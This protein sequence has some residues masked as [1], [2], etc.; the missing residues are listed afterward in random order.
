MK[1]VYLVVTIF[2]TNIIIAQTKIPPTFEYFNVGQSFTSIAVEKDPLGQVWAGTVKKGLFNKSTS[3]TSFNLFTVPNLELYTIKTIATDYSGN[4]WV[5]HNGLLGG[6]ATGGGIELISKLE[7][8][9]HLY[10]RRDNCFYKGVQVQE[11]DGYASRNVKSITVNHNNTVWVAQGNYDVA[12]SS[13][14]IVTPGTLSFKKA[15]SSVFLSKS[16]YSDINNPNP[17]LP[18]PAYTCSPPIGKTAG[19]RVCNSI[20]TDSTKVWMAVSPYETV[21]NE[22]LPARIL[23]YNLDGVF[24]KSY[25]FS[26]IG[27]TPGAV[28][29]GVYTNNKLGAWVTSNFAG[30]GFS[31]LKNGQWYHMDS[32]NFPNI[33]PASAIFNN[34]AIWGN[35]YGNV[36]MGTDKGLIVYDGRGAVNDEKSYTLYNQARHGLISENILG[37]ASELIVDDSPEELNYK[38]T[39]WIA[40]DNGIIK[41]NIGAV[42]TDLNP[43]LPEPSKNSDVK[44]VEEEFKTRAGKNDP[45]YH[46]YFL[47]TEICDTKKKYGIPCTQEQVYKYVAKNVKYQAV[48]PYVFNRDIIFPGLLASL[49]NSDLNQIY[50]I[51]N[52]QK[53]SIEYVSKIFNIAAL[54]GNLKFGADA[55]RRYSPRLFIINSA[56]EIANNL[57]VKSTDELYKTQIRANLKNCVTNTRYKLYN[58][59]N[60]INMRRVF[61]EVVNTEHYAPIILPF[62]PIF[63]P[64]KVKVPKAC[65]PSDFLESDEYDPITLWIDDKNFSMTNYTNKG[66]FLHPGYVKRKIIIKDDGKIYVTTEGKGYHFCN[67]PDGDV[68]SG[69]MSE[70]AKGINVIV[71]SIMFKNIDIN[72]KNAFTNEK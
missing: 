69:L 2:V 33:I 5:G 63:T 3:G 32:S 4:V 9:K 55:I 53:D 34:N 41:A 58:S 1:N 51:V 42:P 17:D 16:Q 19:T 31:V 56:S 62:P 71:G 47:E 60:S 40:T 54:R 30:K 64:F 10:P 24:N 25:A 22:S 27:F 49:N 72:L 45:T 48:H 67:T 59:E 23:E 14:Y 44:L 13:S 6:P 52:E 18:Y 11:N 7:A 70:A 66:H 36:F 20:S 38:L 12:G 46:E 8:P 68:L 37:G 26:E 61:K 43:S 50:Q 39:Q 28:L 57:F 29:N 65:N 21:S 15:G 35:Q